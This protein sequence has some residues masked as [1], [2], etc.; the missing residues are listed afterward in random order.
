[1]TFLKNLARFTRKYLCQSL[2][3]N[4]FASL[5][6]WHRCFLASFAKFLTTP[7]FIEQLWW[8]LQRMVNH[9]LFRGNIHLKWVWKINFPFYLIS[10]SVKLYFK[11]TFYSIMQTLL[12]VGSKHTAWKVYLFGVILV[13]I[14]PHLEWIQRDTEYLSVLS[15]N[16]GKCGSK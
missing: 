15:P 3:F 2:F 7:I 4:K 1:M 6:L 5:R 12:M 16:A 11:R 14:F 13:R 9:L 10:F 8:L